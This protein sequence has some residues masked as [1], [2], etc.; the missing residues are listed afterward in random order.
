VRLLRA[1]AGMMLVL[2]LAA[3]LAACKR[4]ADPPFNPPREPAF[5][6]R[7]RVLNADVFVIDGKHVRLAGAVTPQPVPDARCW[8]EGLAA[9][10]ATAIVR[11]MIKDAIDVRVEPTGKTDAYN[12]AISHVFLDGQDLATKLHDAGMA[13]EAEPDS[14]SFSWCGAISEGGAGAP[15]VKSMM[16]FSRG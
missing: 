13:A 5:G 9:K 16:D 11:E 7:V 6:D 15:D 10:Q 14:R 3:G 4:Q 2:A 1:T 8:A 12:R